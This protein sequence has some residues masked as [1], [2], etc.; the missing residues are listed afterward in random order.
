[1]SARTHNQSA[2]SPGHWQLQHASVGIY[3]WKLFIFFP[4]YYYSIIELARIFTTLDRGFDVP[5][6]LN[7][8][9]SLVL[10]ICI[11]LLALHLRRPKS[12][13]K[14]DWINCTPTKLQESKLQLNNSTSP[15]GFRRRGIC[16]C[17]LLVY[18]Q[19]TKLCPFFY[20]TRE[21]HKLV[22]TLTGHQSR[23]C[24]V[25]RVGVNIPATS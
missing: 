1:M 10:N 3:T 4:F 21:G 17:L 7:Y 18:L 19:W 8:T 23:M 12:L 9:V 25:Y 20:A 15:G 24:M 5:L 11:V 16:F 14:K 22:D 13:I 2:P 6:L